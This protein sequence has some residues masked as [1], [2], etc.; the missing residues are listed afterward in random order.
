MLLVT[1]NES[2]NKVFGYEGLHDYHHSNVEDKAETKK[3]V[4][5]SEINKTGSRDNKSQNTQWLQI[6]YKEVNK[7][8]QR[9][10]QES[11][12]K[13]VLNYKGNGD[14]LYSELTKVKVYYQ[15]KHNLD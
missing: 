3:N 5:S 14:L 2:V 8:P 1:Y 13:E 10:V 7:S 15:R 4:P 6:I 12:R 11:P 9:Q